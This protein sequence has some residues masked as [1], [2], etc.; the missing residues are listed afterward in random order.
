MFVEI[1][2]ERLEIMRR[3]M[4]FQQFFLVLYLLYRVFSGQTNLFEFNNLIENTFPLMFGKTGDT[5]MK[6]S[7]N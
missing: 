4:K 7:S 2:D 5:N 3:R 1:Q 6:I